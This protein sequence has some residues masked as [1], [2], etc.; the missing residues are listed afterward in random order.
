V[1]MPWDFKFFVELETSG[2]VVSRPLLSGAAENMRTYPGKETP[3]MPSSPAALSRAGIGIHSCYVLRVTD[4]VP[5]WLC[6]RAGSHDANHPLHI[7][8]VAVTGF[9]VKFF[10]VV[11]P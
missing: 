4:P 9:L 1:R 11:P 3:L 8:S 2:G 5:C 7:M 6:P 10:L